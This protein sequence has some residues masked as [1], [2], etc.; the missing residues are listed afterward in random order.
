MSS[1]AR[2]FR[3]VLLAVFFICIS[4][5]AISQNYIFAQLNGIPMNTS[6]WNLQGA[7][8]T[9]NITDNN[10]SELMLCDAVLSSSGAIFFN[11]PINLS[12]CNKWIA[13]FDFRIFDG[14]GA[15]GLAFC[16]LDTP[17]VGF[18]LGGGLGIPNTANGL[19]VCFDTWNNCIPFDSGTV[20]QDMPKIEIRWGVG[21]VVNS[22]PTTSVNGECINEPTRDNSDGAISFIR[23]PQYCHAKI[24]YDKGNIQVYVNDV[25]YLTGFQQFNFTGYLGFTASTG[26]YTDRHSIK[27]VIIY[28]E[29]PP[30][31]AG[32]SESFCPVDTVRLGGPTDPSYTYS[33]YPAT[34]L[35]DTTASS[36]RLHLANES[37]I[38]QSYTYFV[39]T[40]YADNPGCASTDSVEVN[41]YPT[42]IVQFTVPA[43]LSR[44]RRRPVL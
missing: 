22:S 19:K 13:E 31:F 18:L 43:G 36:P 9:A 6:G 37:G 30:S 26:G 38:S 33:W 28:T 12:L 24:T 10:N 29:M 40:S 3:I 41:V 5:K 32:Y 11:Q 17:P 42:P 14:T 7:A 4:G 23:S 25:L 21:Y 35:D 15:D 16:F 2:I 1:R 44:R 8:R 27:N 39:K 34:G 20:H